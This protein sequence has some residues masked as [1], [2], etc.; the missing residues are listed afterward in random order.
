MG[1]VIIDFKEKDA[2]EKLYNLIKTLDQPPEIETLISY[3]EFKIIE[4][5]LKITIDEKC[6]VR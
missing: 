2:N 3:D 4:L 1:T 5:Q 6:T